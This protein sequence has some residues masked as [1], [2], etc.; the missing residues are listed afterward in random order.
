MGSVGEKMIARA[1]KAFGFVQ[2]F[3]QRERATSE[4]AKDLTLDSALASLYGFY[5]CTR[6]DARALLNRAKRK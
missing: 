2:S 5:R 4:A 1:E 3:P 6:S